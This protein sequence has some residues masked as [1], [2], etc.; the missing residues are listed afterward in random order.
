MK[1]GI[2]CIEDKVKRKSKPCRKREGWKNRPC[3]EESCESRSVR[4]GKL[5]KGLEAQDKKA[6][7]SWGCRQRGW[8]VEQRMTSAAEFAAEN[9]TGALGIGSRLSSQNNES[10][11]ILWSQD[12]SGQIYLLKILEEESSAEMM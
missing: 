8:A 5:W 11:Q 12:G 10:N 2:L 1:Q 3:D 7:L 9:N 4:K 6:W